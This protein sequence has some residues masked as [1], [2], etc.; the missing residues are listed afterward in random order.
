[1]FNG[2]WLRRQ[3]GAVGG[4]VQL[5]A[6]GLGEANWATWQGGAEAT[7]AAVPVRAVTWGRLKGLYR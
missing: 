6:P 2:M 5:S 3:P 1:V 4:D 7:C